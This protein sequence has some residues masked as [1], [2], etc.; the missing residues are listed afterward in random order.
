MAITFIRV[1]WFGPPRS[2]T[3]NLP[4]GSI[5]CRKPVNP[6]IASSWVSAPVVGSTVKEN[7][8]PPP[9]RTA[10]SNKNLPSGSAVNQRF[11][12]PHH[13]SHSM[14]AVVLDDGLNGD[15]ETRVSAPVLV[16]ARYA[17]TLSL[18]MP[19]T[20]TY[21]AEG[22]APLLPPE[23]PLGG[24]GDVGVVGVGVVEEVAGLAFPP[25]PTR[26]TAMSSSGIARM[27]GGRRIGTLL[28]ARG[29]HP[30]EIHR[31]TRMLSK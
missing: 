10:S 13:L 30:E 7:R 15:P 17:Q 20:Y 8:A 26:M 4:C 29:L 22:E 27:N 9:A 16:S 24:V 25:Q 18:R 23:P 31:A 21:W 12:A 11:V 5:C 14:C 3:R 1:V 28:L 19:L 2:R 6:A